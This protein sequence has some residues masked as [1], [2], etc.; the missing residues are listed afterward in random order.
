[1]TRD[2]MIDT[3]IPVLVNCGETP[4]CARRRLWRM[5]PGALERELLLRG[6]VDYD[7]PL[8]GDEGEEGDDD[9]GGY[10]VLRWAQAPLYSD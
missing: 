10:S 2:E 9:C 3:L 4:T 1:M 8:P 7:D 6:I 5:S